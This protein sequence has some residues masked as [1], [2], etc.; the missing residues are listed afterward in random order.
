MSCIPLPKFIREMESD[1]VE[2]IEGYMAMGTMFIKILMASFPMMFVPQLCDGGPCSMEDKVVSWNWL[3]ITNFITFFTF[4]NLYHAQGKREFYMIDYFDEDDEKSENYLATEI[5]DYPDIHKKIIKLT[6]WLEKSNNVCIVSFILN[7]LYSGIFILST[8]YLDTTTL[9]VLLTNSIL[10]QGKLLQIRAAHQ[11]E[12]LA[13]SS[14]GTKPKKFNIIDVDMRKAPELIELEKGL[15]H[16]KENPSTPTPPKQ[17]LKV[18]VP[19]NVPLT[20]VTEENEEPKEETK[21]SEEKTEPVTQPVTQP[22][23]K[24]S[25]ESS[26]NEEIVEPNVL[27]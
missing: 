6:K 26:N 1:T 19:R 7:T 22:E 8:R 5:L 23:P 12:D 4:C 18:S 21:P 20:I 2:K 16:Q 9:T 27:G 14:V 13:Q 17:P 15:R 25:G 10:V 3:M 11:S 24:S